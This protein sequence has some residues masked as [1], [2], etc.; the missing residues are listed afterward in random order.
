MADED[1]EEGQDESPEPEPRLFTLTEAER[2]RR[3]LEPFSWKPWTAA[4][5]LSGLDNDLSAVS[6]RIMMMGGVIVPYEKLAAVRVRASSSSPKSLKTALNRILE[7]GCVIKD[8]DVGLLDF[9]AV[10]DNEDVYL[11]WK[12]GEDRI[13]FYHR[14]DE[15]FAGRKPID[16]RDTGSWR[17]RAVASPAAHAC[18]DQHCAH[19]DCLPTALREP[20]GFSCRLTP[21]N[22]LKDSASPYLRS[23]AHQPIDW[24]EWGEPAFARAEVGRQAHS[25]GHRRGVV[26]LVPRDRPRELRESR[27][28][29]DHQREFYRRESG[30]RRAPRRRLALSVRRS[31]RSPARAAGRSPVSCYPMAS[32][33][34]GG[35]YF[36]PE[37]Q[38]GRPGFR[39]ILL[40]VAD[41]YRRTNAPSSSAPRITWPMPSLRPKCSPARARISIPPSSTRKSLRSR[42]MFDIKNGGFGRAPEISALFGDR[43]GSR[44]LSSKQTKSIC[45]AM[46]E[47]H[48]RKNGSRRRLRP[49]RRRLSSL[50]GGRTLARPAFRENDLRQFR[51]AAKL[52]ARLAG[53]A[54]SLSCGRPPKASS[55]G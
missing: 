13:R 48:A 47:T 20:K 4:R 5:N 33:F 1:D 12:L 22:R 30:S 31:A 23:A 53:D 16:P 46:V 54:E 3:E 15:G 8:L 10:I 38:M 11:C 52:S 24:H 6:A 45:C 39:R 34:F 18:P 2:A 42:S 29:Q 49:A 21:E 55:A 44:A 17:Y 41:S 50:L 32:P 43:F 36:P 35:T 28:R 26:P 14:Q 37:D 40:A 25:S 7:T 51:A 27:N 19:Q 9:P